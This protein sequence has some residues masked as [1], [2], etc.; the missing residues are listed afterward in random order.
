M[1]PYFIPY[2]KINSKWIKDINKQPETIKLLE[3]KRERKLY[4]VNFGS[5]F[6][7]MTPKDRPKRKKERKNRQMRLQKVLKLMCRVKENK[8]N[9]K[10]IYRIGENIFK[11]IPDERSIPRIST[12]PIQLNKKAKQSNLKK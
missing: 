8:H 10:A 2:T 12:E 5:D 3:E 4:N 6:L 9:E 1:D 11:T 7:D